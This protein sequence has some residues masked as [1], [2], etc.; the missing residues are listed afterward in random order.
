M[1]QF[2][3]HA[4]QVAENVRRFAEALPESPELQAILGYVQAWY[5]LELESG[6]WVFAP[7]KFV[8]YRDNTAREYVRTYRKLPDGGRPEEILRTMFA[9][10]DLGSGLGRTLMDE[11]IDYVGEYGRSPRRRARISVVTDATSDGAARSPPDHALLSRISTN[12]EVCSGRPCIKGTRMRVSDVV[13]ML[14]A[15]A[16]RAE[17]LEDFPYLT[18]ED[19]SAALAYAARATDHRVI[20]AA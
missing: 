17:I 14:A 16:T 9:D 5:A 6:E 15:G 2:V 1:A 7:S 19:V 8:A 18:A 11:L 10:V 12:P 20:R 3:T 4:K 13:D